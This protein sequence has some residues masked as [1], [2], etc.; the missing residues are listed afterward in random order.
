MLAAPPNLPP[1]IHR[2]RAFTD[3]LRMSRNPI[4]IFS[5][6]SR[7]LGDT[8]SFHFGGV[9]KTIVTCN[10]G[11][12][13]HILQKNYTNYRKSDIQVKRMGHFL[14]KGLLTSHGE[15]WLTQR[16]LIQEGFHKDKL[17]SFIQIMDEVLSESLERLEAGMEGEPIDICPLMNELTFRIVTSTL[18]STR[19]SDNELATVS[20]SITNIQQFIVRQ[21]VQPYLN[22]W[23]KVSGT[24]NKYETMRNESDNVFRNNITDRRKNNGQH[25]D[26]LQTLL[27]ARYK[28]TGTG[29]TDEQ[30]LMET[31]QLIV[32]GHETSSTSLS[33]ILYLLTQNPDCL[34]KVKKEIKDNIG[35]E[36]INIYHLHKL[37]YTVQVI[38]ESLRLYPPFW[39]VD[40]EA[41]EDDE[42]LGYF[43]PKNSMI[44]S[45]I[46]GVHHSNTYWKDPEKFDPERFSKENVKKQVPFSHLPF[47]GGPRIC[48]GANYAQLQMLMILA[49]IFRKYNFEL[50]QDH[51]AEIGP[52]IILRPKDG[53]K[54]KFT[55]IK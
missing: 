45:F 24:L 47:G 19:L 14:G 29:M 26:M 6:Y 25:T 43:I 38:E 22:P 48:I 18:F 23:F 21:I 5:E 7:R 46:Y 8:Y 15:Y 52:M 49:T 50:A 12:M 35:D 39:M 28:E 1:Q 54:M 53:I 17:V 31:M 33:W 3:S 51:P 37:E 13:Q 20:D 10:P 36:P 34:I 2:I 32:A 11:V 16:R 27:D 55:K 40:R 9:Q 44:I 30:I 4:E 42:V 41:N